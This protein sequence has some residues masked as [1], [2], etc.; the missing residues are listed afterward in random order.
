MASPLAL[1]ALQS[2]LLETTWTW[3][4]HLLRANLGLIVVERNDWILVSRTRETG[5]LATGLGVVGAQLTYLLFCLFLLIKK[6]PFPIT[7]YKYES[8][9]YLSLFN[10][11]N[12]LPFVMSHF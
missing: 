11:E 9:F 12:L 4:Q 10:K 1:S 2:V 8:H 5:T 3:A 7:A 6:N